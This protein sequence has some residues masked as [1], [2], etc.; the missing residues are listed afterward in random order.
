MLGSLFV[1]AHVL[2]RERREFAGDRVL[3]MTAVR[4]LALGAVFGAA[5]WALAPEPAALL[6]LA[7]SPAWQGL[8]LTL[9]VACTLF[10]F[11]VMNACQPRITATEAGLI[12]TL[13]PVSAS[14]L[15][16]FL[17][18]KRRR[19]LTRRLTDTSR[20]ADVF[21]RYNRYLILRLSTS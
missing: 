8:T 7:G 16:L 15:A 11:V 9:T 2:W 1:M 20:T 5:A 14:A 10:C 12:Y 18:E 13:E 17:S 3:P 4:F 21:R 6:A 19:N